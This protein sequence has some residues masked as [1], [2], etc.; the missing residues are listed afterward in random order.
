MTPHEQFYRKKFGYYPT[1]EQF[2]AFDQEALIKWWKLTE[3]W[4]VVGIEDTKVKAQITNETLED[5]RVQTKII[6]RNSIIPWVILFCI[7][8]AYVTGITLLLHK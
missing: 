1:H 5:I 2:M 8:I 4:Y 6:T 3:E 7:T